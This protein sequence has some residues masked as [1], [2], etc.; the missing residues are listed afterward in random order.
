MSIQLTAVVT[1]ATGFVGSHLVDL[2]IQKGYKVKCLVRKSSNLRWLDGKPVELVYGGLSDVEH[3][4]KTFEDA[5]YIYHIAGVVKSINAQGYYDGNVQTTKNVLDAALAATHLKGILVTSSMAASG[6]APRNGTVTEDMPC[7]PD[8]LYGQSKIQQEELTRAYMDKLPIVIVRPPAV[9]GERDTEVLTIFKTINSGI[10]GR[11]GVLGEKHAS[12]IYVGDLVNGMHLAATNPV[13][14]GKT[15]FLSSEAVYTW[16]EVGN[17]V[18][19]TLGRFTI[20][21]R[22]PHFVIFLAGGVGELLERWFKLDVALNLERAVRI[23]QSDWVCSPAKAVKELGFRQ[24]I[25]IEDG[26]RRTLDWYK[27][28]KWL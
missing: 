19:S 2:L 28:N 7:Q 18:A 15:Y 4:K 23:T 5:D 14:M 26:L 24:N 10:R 22:V 16:K 8:G 11:I 9:Y 21:V 25:S 20:P 13:A 17:I 6:S 3:L 27:A 1:G 12:L